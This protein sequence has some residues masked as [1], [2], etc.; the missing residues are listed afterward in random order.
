[1]NKRALSALA[2]G[3]VCFAVALVCGGSVLVVSVATACGVIAGVTIL[4]GE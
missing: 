2:W 1:M 4:H 3:A